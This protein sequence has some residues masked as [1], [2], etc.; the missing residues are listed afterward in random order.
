MKRGG[1][2]RRGAAART[3]RDPKPQGVRAALDEALAE[4]RGKA[5]AVGEVP[6]D[7][8]FLYDVLLRKAV[9]LLPAAAP[10]LLYP[11]PVPAFP[12]A[13]RLTSPTYLQLVRTMPCS[14]PDCPSRANAPAP[15][16]RPWFQA[17]QLGRA[18]CDPNHHPGR[19]ASGGGSDLETHP[20]CRPCHERVT[21]HKIPRDLLDRLVA[22]TLLQVV[23]ALR[24][25]RLPREVLGQITAE[26]L[27]G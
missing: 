22:E 12:R 20:V 5:A 2:L 13:Q 4:L 25:G 7:A 21:L 27:A 18:Q 6:H 9:V 17:L 1:N 8:A 19:G 14:L 16:N 11:A 26:A 10:P 15:P 24:A 23:Q 3:Q